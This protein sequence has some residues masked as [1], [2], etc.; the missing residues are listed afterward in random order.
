MHQSQLIWQ[1]EPLTFPALELSP[2]RDW[3][4]TAG[5]N[6]KNDVCA[7]IGLLRRLIH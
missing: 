6:C 2:G 1:F 7:G 3:G 5:V 4:I